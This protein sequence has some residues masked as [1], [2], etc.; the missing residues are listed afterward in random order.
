VSFDK[1][2]QPTQKKRDDA[3]RRGQVPRSREVDSALVLL[4]AL[5]ALRFGGSALWDGLESLLYD[6]LTSLERDPF[7]LEVTSIV[8]AEL[9]WRSIVLLLPL[10]F[11]VLAVALL[12]G[13]AQAGGPL[14]APQ[15]LKPQVSR[16]SLLKGAKRVFASKQSLVQLA[17]TLLKFVVIGGIAALTL[18]EHSDEMTAMGVAQPLGESLDTLVGIGFDL[19]LRVAVVL[20]LLAVLDYGFQRYD[21]AGQLRMTK[22]EVKDEFR[23]QEGDPQ[24]RAQRD[25]ARRAFL[26]RVMESVRGADVVLVNPTHVAVALSYEP[27]SNRAPLVVAKG[28][29][30][31]AQRIREFALE[32]GIPVI[33]NPPL[34][35]AIYGAV[36]M[37]REIPPELYEA[38]AEVL[39]FVYRLRYARL[40]A[41]A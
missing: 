12:G 22:Q 6:S 26:A 1:T 38:V 40:G 35:R 3:R 10:L 41:A 33:R 13:M 37:G 30:L 14:F 20:I 24:V 34:A 17:K 28:Q 36:P 9:V 18:W 27:T 8:G 21:L 2:E 32:L 5:A 25:R 15:A 4:A 11:A 19:T 23:Q 31:I 39:A 16:L 29:E 7:T